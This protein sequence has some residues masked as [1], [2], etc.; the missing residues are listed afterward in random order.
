MPFIRNFIASMTNT[1]ILGKFQHGCFQRLDNAVSSLDI[2]V[3][4]IVRNVA[5]ILLSAWS[6]DKAPHPL[7]CLH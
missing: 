1:R 3:G 7:A 5:D 6:E 2:I 4:D